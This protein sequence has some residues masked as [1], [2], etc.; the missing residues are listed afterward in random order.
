M[1]RF[2]NFGLFVAISI[3]MAMLLSALSMAADLKDIKGHWA[4]EYIEYGV[5]AGYISGYDDGTFLPDK[6]VTRAEF[7][8]M[9]NSAVKITS[10]GSAKAEFTDVESKDWFFN[11]VKKA[12]NAGYITGYEDGSFR[13]NNS[14]TRQEAAVILSRIVL[15]VAERKDVSSFVDGKIIDSWA[16][17]AVSMIAAKGYIKGDE[18]GKFLPKNSL[19]RSQAAKLICEFV[20]NE[21]IVNGDKNV[22]ASSNEIVFSETLF[23]DNVIFDFEDD[24]EIDVTFKNCKILGNIIIRGG[25]VIVSLED[26]SAKIVN[27]NTDDAY[28]GLDKNSSVKH[29]YIYAPVTL[30]GNGFE[31][32]YLSGDE[33]SEGM[34]NISGDC[35]KVE[36]S[37]DVIVSADIIEKMVITSKSNLVLQSGT[38]K[39]LEVKAEA[40][41]STINLAKK[42]VVE[43]ASN[44]A[45]VTYVGS[46]TVEIANNEVTG[47]VYDGVTVET[48]TGKKAEGDGTPTASS[49]FFDGVTVSPSKNKTGVS[50][51]TNISFVFKNKILDNKGNSI[52]AEYL[53]EN[54]ELRKGSASGT[55]T[56]FT[57]SISS[58]KNILV[59]PASSLKAS[60]KYY[61]VIP[62]GTFTDED[63][64]E[65]DEYVT[66]FTT[67]AAA[68]DEDDSSAGSDD[69]DEPT[70][71]M[72]PKS[73]DDEVS[74]NTTIK[75]TFSGTLK[76]YSGTLDEEYVEETIKIYEESTSGDTVDF[77]AYISSKTI[78]LTPSR[79]LGDTKYY[80]VIPG[81]K[82]KVGGDTL[83]KTTMS[84]TTEE[85][86][87]ITVSPENGATGVS[88]MPEITVSFAEPML[89]L[90]KNHDALTEDYIQDDVL[91][92]RK[93]SAT[94]TGDEY[95]VSY[96]VTEI[97][98][99][100]RKFVIVPDEELES[101]ISYYIIIQEESLYGKTSE[102]ENK[103]VTSSFKTA[104]AMAPMFYPTDGKENVSPAT[105][106]RVSFSSELLTYSTKSAER[107]EVT[108]EYLDELI[109]GDEDGKN[110]NRISLKR[111]T[112]L[113]DIT[114]TLDSDGKTII[115]TPDDALLE[116]KTY[117]I[118]VAKNCFYSSDG[119]KANVAGTATFNTNE[120]LSPTFTPK[121][122]AEG[123]AVTTNPT[124]KFS[125]DIFNNEGEEIKNSYLKNTAIKFVDQYGEDVEFTASIEGST[126]TVEPE[127]NLE[128]NMEYTLT[129]AAGTI[130]NED[131]IANAEKSVT[132]KTKIS[133]TITITPEKAETSVSPLVNPTVKFGTA[134]LTLDYGEVDADYAYDYIFLSEAKA[135]SD[136]DA[137]NVVPATIDVGEDG[138]TFT[139]I[140]ENALEFGKKYYV[141][142]A[143]GGFYYE[144]EETKNSTAS[145][146]FTV[147]KEPVLSKVS[148]S[149]T[150]ETQAKI[151]FT[152]SVKGTSDDELVVFVVEDENGEVV[153][154]KVVTTTASTTITIRGLQAGT[155]YNFTTYLLCAGE[156]KSNEIEVSPLT[157]GTAPDPE[158]EDPVP[159]PNETPIA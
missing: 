13:P 10:T 50:L 6:T 142:V 67:K 101:G 27:V 93:S 110:K 126:I 78:T 132:F 113:L 21:N 69:E 146:Y 43:S 35:K 139:L 109:N 105:E 79:L 92:F 42:A 108:D 149:S 38:V 128:G 114:V 106:I 84:F 48:T 116:E 15:P 54:L 102:S 51:T 99:N 68:D 49:E 117:T 147:I 153:G 1:K 44:K 85:G 80:V 134:V 88:T 45:P 151:S 23:T 90:N 12:E 94:K 20:K 4:E 136:V 2:S 112:K 138:R 62:E 61:V 123:V 158:E 137:D 104:S 8:K 125:E 71:T 32:I 145:S 154:T 130:T 57:A 52:D 17:D 122:D 133:Y 115:I 89:Q 3:C 140:P 14:V 59:D 29:T 33:L 144:D 47:V 156:I 119:K 152:S 75:L 74:V 7:S 111:G 66:Y 70:V 11:E 103:K 72:S 82:F 18:S 127:E 37:G 41:G 55:K 155:E 60:T 91:L 157:K 87:A 28:I 141:N 96:S 64:R 97:A 39:S 118:S 121:A 131:G 9:I 46:G 53:E 95:Q 19:T 159:G 73:G 36:V 77:T 56:A 135:A 65:N 40:K 31:N 124:I 129:L 63:G 34:V 143:K 26:S 30:V 16:K 107:V 150:T 22:E 5:E 98:E 24:V 120:A 100:G 81:N 58:G 76:A 148:V 83:S 86:L 25:K